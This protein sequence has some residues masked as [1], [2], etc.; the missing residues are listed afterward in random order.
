MARRSKDSLRTFPVQEPS[1]GRRIRGIAAGPVYQ[2]GA[3]VR[4]LFEGKRQRARSLQIHFWICSGARAE[5]PRA[6]SARKIPCR[7]CKAN[8]VTA[9]WSVVSMTR[10]VLLFARQAAL[11]VGT[12]KHLDAMFPTA[13]SMLERANAAL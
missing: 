10:T 13:R 12:A 3:N 6:S 9:H 4:V 2:N 8:S 11:A 5:A 1:T 7:E